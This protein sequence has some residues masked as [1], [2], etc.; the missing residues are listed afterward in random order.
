MK[1]Q[2]RGRKGHKFDVLL[3]HSRFSRESCNRKQQSERR[4]KRK[5]ERVGGV[6]GGF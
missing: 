6:E 3:F 1:C 5:K 4:E 2:N